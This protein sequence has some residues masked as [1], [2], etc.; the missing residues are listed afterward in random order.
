MNLRKYNIHLEQMNGVVYVD[1]NNKGRIVYPHESYYLKV[2][3]ICRYIFL[4]FW[5]KT[6]FASTK[7][8]DFYAELVQGRQILMFY[9]TYS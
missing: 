7:F 5:L 2:T 8:C 6:P 4:R 3:I 1:N 9:T